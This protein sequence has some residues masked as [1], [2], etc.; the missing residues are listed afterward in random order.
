MA[1]SSRYLIAFDMD[2]TLLRPDLSV[3][4]KTKE[5]ISRLVS[6]GHLVTVAT[7]RPA[8]VAIPY[9]RDLKMNGPL[10]SYNGSSVIDPNNP[11][12]PAKK[13]LYK[14]ED[15][16][17]FLASFGYEKFANILCE[18][19]HTMVIN[20]Y[21][22]ELANFYHPEGMTIKEGNVIDLLDEDCYAVILKLYNHFEDARLVRCGFQYPDV[23]VRF[24]GHGAGR[25]AEMYFPRV[26]KLSALEYARE[27]T[28][29]DREHVIVVG[30]GDNDVEMLSMYPHSIGMVNG[31]PQAKSRASQVSEFDNSHDGAAIAVEKMIGDLEK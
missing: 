26:S 13:Y 10:I 15:V 17:D 31:D 1:S 7:G 11:D 20:A 9:Y 2:G 22:E 12:Y 19:E 18:T 8:R 16:K 27:S 3:G 24:W 21:S 5:I 4:E 30:D 6:Q 23:G 25:L 28:G 14:K 29:I